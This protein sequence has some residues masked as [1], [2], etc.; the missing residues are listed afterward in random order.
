MKPIAI[1]KQYTAPR[2]QSLIHMYAVSSLYINK[3]NNST[4]GS[5]PK[6]TSAEEK[7]ILNGLYPNNK[8]NILE[9]LWKPFLNY[10]FTSLLLIKV[11]LKYWTFKHVY[12]HWTCA[13]MI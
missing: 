5:L 8:W 1:I 9:A 11:M 4:Q 3:G 12:Y 2:N 7:K 6:I 13:T 10:L